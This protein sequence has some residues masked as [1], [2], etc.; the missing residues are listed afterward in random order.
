MDSNTWCV[1]VTLASFRRIVAL[2][3][4]GLAQGEA[5]LVARQRSPILTPLDPLFASRPMPSL[6]AASKVR[7]DR[8]TSFLG[9]WSTGTRGLP[10][11]FGK[12]FTESCVQRR[13]PIAPPSNERPL[14]V[15]SEK[16]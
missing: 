1:C 8:P 4:E 10:G 3:S 7:I 14:I 2:F 6:A 16:S 13:S 15:Y 12:R 11:R 9:E 5:K